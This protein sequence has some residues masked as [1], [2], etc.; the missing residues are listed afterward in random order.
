MEK[1][2]KIQEKCKQQK[3]CQKFEITNFKEKR[4]LLM[5]KFFKVILI[6]PAL[7]T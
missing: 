2:V 3:N 1:I 4:L 6:I 7:N 5:N